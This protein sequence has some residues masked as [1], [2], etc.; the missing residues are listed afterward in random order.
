MLNQNGEPKHP[1]ETISCAFDPYIGSGELGFDVFRHL[2]K[3]T[4]MKDGQLVKVKDIF[5]D[6]VKDAEKK[7]TSG[8]SYPSFKIIDID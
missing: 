2:S 3:D 5:I 6:G 1:D 7:Y 4:L 8:A